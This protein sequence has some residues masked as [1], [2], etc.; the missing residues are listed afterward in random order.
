MG[1]VGTG[2]WVWVA[3]IPMLRGGWVAGKWL[4]V[5][6]WKWVAAAGTGWSKQGGGVRGCRCRGLCMIYRA[7]H[8]CRCCMTWQEARCESQ[9]GKTMQTA[10]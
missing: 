8:S 1:A 6:G 4:E 10:Q 5:G 7:T 9:W 2:G 3:G